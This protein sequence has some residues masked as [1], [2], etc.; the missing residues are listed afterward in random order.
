M[1]Y[2]TEHVGDH[3]WF[4]SGGMG[5][6]SVWVLNFAVFFIFTNRERLAKNAKIKPPQNFRV[7]GNYIPIIGLVSK[8]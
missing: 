1:L 5:M 6:D 2:G 8:L 4:H 7:Y 3:V